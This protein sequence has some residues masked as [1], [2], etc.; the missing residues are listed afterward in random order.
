M[1]DNLHVIN[2]MFFVLISFNNLK[3]GQIGQEEDDIPGIDSWEEVT[4][5]PASPQNDIPE[6]ESSFMEGPNQELTIPLAEQVYSVNL[7]LNMA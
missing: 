2:Y 5:G 7:K 6:D 4:S 1:Y 3:C